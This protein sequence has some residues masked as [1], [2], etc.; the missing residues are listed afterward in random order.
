MIG[1]LQGCFEPLQQL[2]ETISFKPDCDQLWFVGDLV[3]RGP[4][5]LDCLRFVVLA[6]AGTQR[7]QQFPVFRFNPNNPAW[8]RA[9]IGSGVGNT[10]SSQ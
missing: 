3:N 6:N 1:D 5:S 8:Y 10:G 4:Q 9:P 7:Y 2:L